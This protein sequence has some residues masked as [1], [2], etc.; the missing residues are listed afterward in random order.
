MRSLVMVLIFIL[1]WAVPSAILSTWLMSRL[2]TERFLRWFLGSLTITTGFIFAVIEAI[3]LS[4]T[5]H[6]DVVALLI[7]FSYFPLAGI[8]WGLLDYYL[9]KHK[10]TL[11][12]L[13]AKLCLPPLAAVI[14]GAVE[15]AGVVLSPIFLLLETLQL[16]IP[17]VYW[18]IVRL[19]L[20]KILG[21]EEDLKFELLLAGVGFI[22]G[23]LA[24]SLI[25]G[26]HSGLT[27]VSETE[28]LLL[29]SLIPYAV[30][31]LIDGVF[32][33]L[34][35]GKNTAINLNKRAV[36][37]LL[38]LYLSATFGGYVSL[39]WEMLAHEGI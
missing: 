32:N 14:V 2:S 11:T 5:L 36:L 23:K 31:G 6:H 19:S 29:L 1:I 25:F 8:V 12:Q 38:S 34:I 18:L 21:L 39:M 10:L 20:K 35:K 3:K 22:S 37:V 4:S 28:G 16:M 33:L 26:F 27:L 24:Y 9:T 17:G 30:I 15:I 13:L 7:L